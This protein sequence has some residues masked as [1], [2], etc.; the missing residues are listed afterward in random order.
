MT[1][2]VL[3]HWGALHRKQAGLA[4]VPHEPGAWL[5]P[6]DVVEDERGLIVRMEIAGVARRDI[7]VWL[8]SGALVVEGSRPNPCRRGLRFRQL[9][10]EY[11]PF[12]RILPLPCGVDGRRATAALEHG[13]LEIWLPRTRRPMTEKIIMVVMT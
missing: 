2:N 8:E 3:S 7:H 6:T 5:P 1:T 10:M 9:E 12:R 13:V 11:G 4:A